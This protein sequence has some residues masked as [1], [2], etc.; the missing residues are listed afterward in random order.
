MDKV[1]ALLDHGLSLSMAVRA[2]LGAR[3]LTSVALKHGVNRS[4]LTSGLSGA[5]VLT[6]GEIDALIAELGG[7]RA[8]WHGLVADAMQARARAAGALA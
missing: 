5:R 7:T 4:N 8:E 1:K 2:A 6:D 3:R